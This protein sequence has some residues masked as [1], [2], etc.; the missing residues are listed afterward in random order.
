MGINAGP[1]PMLWPEINN[2][3][4]CECCGYLQDIKMLQDDSEIE[5]RKCIRCKAVMVEY[6]DA[7]L[8]QL[9]DL[10]TLQRR[11]RPMREPNPADALSP[12]Y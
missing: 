6:W 12:S 8:G 11:D 4:I 9:V 7:V 5:V 1:P 2:A 10:D 3:G